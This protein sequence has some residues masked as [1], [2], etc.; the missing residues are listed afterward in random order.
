RASRAAP[1]ATAR[2]PSHEL[3]PPRTARIS[4][5]ADAVE[6][7]FT[8]NFVPQLYDIAPCI[9]AE[10]VTKD[11]RA[12]ASAQPTSRSSQWLLVSQFDANT[13]PRSMSAFLPVGL[14]R[15]PSLGPLAFRRF[16]PLLRTGSSRQSITTDEKCPPRPNHRPGA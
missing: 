14:S 11:A 7:T 8:M 16:A 4:A 6:S 10:G 13:G 12:N 1:P 5:R 15:P 3:D 2:S 9:R